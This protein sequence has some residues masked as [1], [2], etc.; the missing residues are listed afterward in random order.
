[1]ICFVNLCILF[2]FALSL[3]ANAGSPDVVQVFTLPCTSTQE[4]D[5][6]FRYLSSKGVKTIIFRTFKN[7]GDTPYY[8]K[9]ETTSTGV[10][11]TT[12]NEPLVSDLLPD[13][14]ASAHRHGLE[15][16]A[17][18]TT[19]KCQW[20][21]QEN[22]ELESKRIN[23]RTGEE[24]SSNQLDIFNPV[25][26]QKI[27]SLLVDLSETG[28]DGILIQD[29]LVSRQ[30]DDFFTRGWKDFSGEA[31]R[32]SH[33]ND[34]F[35]ARPESV[36]YTDMYYR[37]SRYKS[38]A[39]ASFLKTCIESV[40]LRNSKLKIAVN[41]YFETV[42]TPRNARNW[43]AQDLEELLKLDIDHFA[44][45]AYQRQIKK[46]LNIS[47]TKVNQ[48]L[49]K[50]SQHVQSGYMIPNERL[51]WKLQVQ[52]WRTKAFIPESELCET[53]DSVSN[54]IC[55]AVPYR[56]RISVKSMLNCQSI[57]PGSR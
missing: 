51:W 52:D 30:G 3:E 9:Q 28:I 22:P 41:V 37:W 20:I 1:M 17:W 27:L 10:Y 8:L 23:V 11:F 7:P 45:M 6:E 26:R 34:L 38:E 43:L 53:L 32:A 33:L 49:A 13:V 42:Y 25:V 4:L 36:G 2:F 21:I 35:I 40:K 31:F 57:T 12:R 46:E 54:S 44:I 16:Y 56:G 18:I 55:V 24:Q 5:E 14:I 48:L 29:D 39:L 15:C 47:S 19:R 50:A